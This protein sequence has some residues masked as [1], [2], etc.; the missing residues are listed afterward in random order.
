MC[1][2]REEV[3]TDVFKRKFFNETSEV[4]FNSSKYDFGSKGATF[5]SGVKCEFDPPQGD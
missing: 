4:F 3:N 1:L 5:F 2:Y